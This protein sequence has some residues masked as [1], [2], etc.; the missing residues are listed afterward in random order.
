MLGGPDQEVWRSSGAG[1]A[2]SSLKRSG[3]ERAAVRVEKDG[4]GGGEG[5]DVLSRKEFPECC[6]LI[7]SQPHTLSMSLSLFLS[8]FFFSSLSFI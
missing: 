2:I 6:P 7:W 1:E 4:V 8:L 3:E 5:E